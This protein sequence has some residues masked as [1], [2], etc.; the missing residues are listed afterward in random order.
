MKTLTIAMLVFAGFI[1]CYT[2]T[3]NAMNKIKVSEKGQINGKVIDYASGL[4]LQSASIELYNS[5]NSSLVVGTI[6][7]N[8][9]EFT[10]TMIE[11]GNYYLEISLDGYYNYMANNIVIKKEGG[12]TE[13]GEIQ[14]YHKLNKSVRMTSKN[15]LPN[16]ESG[17][18]LNNKH[19]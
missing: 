11:P 3:L 18:A 14:L 13:I 1:L 2:G 19:Y 10:I 15:R 7:N 16:K 6:T 9:G 5:D 12:K 8:K 4:N 17:F